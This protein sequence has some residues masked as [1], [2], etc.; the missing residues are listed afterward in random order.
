MPTAGAA[1]EVGIYDA[2]GRVVT[3]LFSGTRAEGDHQIDWDGRDARGHALS[4]G[5]Y[6]ARLRALGMTA[7]VRILRLP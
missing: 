1:H 7:S 4:G 3:R 2:A 6:L 5:I